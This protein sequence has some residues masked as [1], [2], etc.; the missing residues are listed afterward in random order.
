MRVRPPQKHRLHI[1]R[2]GVIN[3]RDKG[4]DGRN[5]KARGRLWLVGKDRLIRHLIID[6][7]RGFQRL[8]KS[9]WGMGRWK[10]REVLMNEDIVGIQ[11]VAYQLTWA[12]NP[13]HLHKEGVLHVILTAI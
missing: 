9:D 7:T 13:S 2:V 10:Y 6:I 8:I 12:G 3:G 11:S 1:R 5:R 4:Q